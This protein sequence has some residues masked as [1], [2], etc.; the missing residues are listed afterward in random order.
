MDAIRLTSSSTHYRTIRESDMYLCATAKK[1]NEVTSLWGKIVDWFLGT[2]KEAAKVTFFRLLNS[3]TA[4]QQ[5]SSFSE[6]RQYVSPACQDLLT[7]RFDSNENS[8]FRIGDLDIPLHV[9]VSEKN[10]EEQHEINLKDACHLLCSMRY[11]DHNVVTEFHSFAVGNLSDRNADSVLKKQELFLNQ[12]PCLL[13][14][15]RLLGLHKDDSQGNFSYAI[16]QTVE[17][18]IYQITGD[19]DKSVQAARNAENLSILA[20]ISKYPPA[21][22]EAL[23]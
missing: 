14:A 4:A 3:D 9:T 17:R 13:R 20:S 15:L 18:M 2:K 7:W 10:I 12:T 6:L 11:T 1:E 23:G 21:E 22:P 5:L 8:V 19:D 16:H